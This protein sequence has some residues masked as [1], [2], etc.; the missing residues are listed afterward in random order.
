MKKRKP[1]ASIDKLFALIERDHGGCDQNS[2]TLG[3]AIRHGYAMVAVDSW[4]GSGA[5][6]EEF[7]KEAAKGLPFS[8]KEM[9]AEYELMGR[10]VPQVECPHCNAVLWNPDDCGHWCDSCAK[11]LPRPAEVAL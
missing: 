11:Q 4:I 6:D 3:V 1:K 10:E 5:A 9:Q 8:L 2:C 7:H